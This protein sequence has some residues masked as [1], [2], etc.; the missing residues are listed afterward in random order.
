MALFA[1]QTDR[2]VVGQNLLVASPVDD[3]FTE[4]LMPAYAC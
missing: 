2:M 1:A 3:C 4:A